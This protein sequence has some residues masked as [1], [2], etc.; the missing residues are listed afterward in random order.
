MQ[1]SSEWGGIVPTKLKL[2]DVGN[3]PMSVSKYSV[4]VT[5]A[6]VK[7]GAKEISIFF[8]AFGANSKGEQSSILNP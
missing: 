5:R 3:G 1:G 6:S 2:M 4:W 8:D 7:S